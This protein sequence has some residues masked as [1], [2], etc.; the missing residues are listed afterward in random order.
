MNRTFRWTDWQ[1]LQLFQIGLLLT[2]LSNCCLLV[3]LE[4]ILSCLTDFNL[5]NMCPNVSISG[6]CILE[7]YSRALVSRGIMCTAILRRPENYTYVISHTK[8]HICTFTDCW[9][10]ACVF[11]RKLVAMCNEAVRH[12]FSFSTEIVARNKIQTNILQRVLNHST[13]TK[14]RHKLTEYSG[15]CRNV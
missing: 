3:F 13:W 1:I 15:L 8:I 10:I 2:V 9:L 6:R 12:T 14:K 5:L 4:L 11:G 7:A